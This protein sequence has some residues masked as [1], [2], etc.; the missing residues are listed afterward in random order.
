MKNGV[1][2]RVALIDRRGVGND[3]AGVH[4]STSDAAQDVQ[5]EHHLDRDVH[6]KHVKGLKHD[7][8]HAFPPRLQ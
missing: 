6:G 1:R 3:V 7:L 5:E 8:R 4:D 2:Q